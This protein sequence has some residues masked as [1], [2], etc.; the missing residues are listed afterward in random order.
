[1]SHALLQMAG[2]R[3]V[4]EY[5]RKLTVRDDVFLTVMEEM[6]KCPPWEVRALCLTAADCRWCAL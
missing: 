3:P 1:M 6:F 4:Y 5:L 2:S